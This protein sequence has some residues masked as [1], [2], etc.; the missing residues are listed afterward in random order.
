LLEAEVVVLG[1]G[2]AGAVCALNLAPFRRVVLVE[3][4]ATPPP[5][6]GD[7][8]PPA[9]R[10]LLTDMGLWEAFLAEKH[11]PCHANRARWGS[12]E[13]FETDLLRD[14]D[15]QGWHV[16]RARFELWLRT[17][18]AERGAQLLAPAGLEV[19]GRENGVW[20]LRLSTAQGDIEA[21]A[22]LLIDASG[23]P[24]T[25]ARRLGGQ[26]R[27]LDKLV[28]AWLRGRDEA[29]GRA[30]VTYVEAEPEGWW[31]SA[32][33]PGGRR[34]LAFHTDADLPSAASARR[35]ETLLARARRSPSLA[36]TL[37]EAAFNPE[38]SPF[39]PSP[40][41]FTS[42][43]STAL[44]PPIGERWLATGDAALAFDPL[45]AQGLLNAFIT[46]LAAAEAADCHLAGAGEALSDYAEA[47]EG[48]ASTY[49]RRLAFAYSQE[50]RWREQ[51]FWQ[52]R[53]AGEAAARRP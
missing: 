29:G 46:G 50:Q 2:P 52:R 33:L 31:Y 10:R 23:R 8:L 14:S 25:L 4:R 19:L 38:L 34:V 13:P 36:A 41:G 37:A 35:P 53:H 5:R 43:Q 30:G 17:I 3:R 51:P 47:L 11:A 27:V 39:E 18:A 16:D 9:A 20:R 40:F 7:S 45:S 44:T 42:A 21:R 26:R 32:P 6:I 12:A 49:R 24:A 1:A 15:G 48:I 28:C 22:G